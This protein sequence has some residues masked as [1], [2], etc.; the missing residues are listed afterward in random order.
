[1]NETNNN[2]FL[3]IVAVFVVLPLLYFIFTGKR[4]NE[5]LGDMVYKFF[6]AIIKL[7]LNPWQK[8]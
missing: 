6:G 7:I 2:G 4:G 8:K 1:M 5:W 3:L